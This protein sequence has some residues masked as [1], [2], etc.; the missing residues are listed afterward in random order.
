MAKPVKRLYVVKPGT[1]KALTNPKPR[2]IRASSQ[3]AALRFAT[4]GI[5]EVKPANP[6]D[7]AGLYTEG[8]KAEDAS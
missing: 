4:A 8:V 6:E 5:Y 1:V 3:A 7:V 2:L